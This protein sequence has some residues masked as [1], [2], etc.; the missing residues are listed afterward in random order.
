MLKLSRELVCDTSTCRW[1]D[2]FGSDRAN[3]QYGVHN[4]SLFVEDNWLA[5][6]AHQLRKEI[7]LHLPDRDISYRFS[8]E[9]MLPYK[10]ETSS[11]YVEPFYLHKA[12]NYLPPSPIISLLARVQRYYWLDTDEE[13][14]DPRR[15][16]EFLGVDEYKRIRERAGGKGGAI[17]KAESE[18]VL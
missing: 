15:P 13:F 1:Q 9:T 18:A 11:D 14:G 5:A 6:R 4:A 17:T 16:D 10:S 8:A 7:P 3:S 2:A 12:W